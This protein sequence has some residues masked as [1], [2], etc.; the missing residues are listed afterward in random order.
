MVTNDEVVSRAGT[1]RPE[2][3]SFDGSAEQVAAAQALMRA[4]P[5]SC[6]RGEGN[7]LSPPTQCGDPLFRAGW[8]P[9][10]DYARAPPEAISAFNP[11]LGA[12]DNGGEDAC[13][14]PAAALAIH[15]ALLTLRRVSRARKVHMAYLIIRG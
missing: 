11:A 8:F 5:V 14:A 7:T 1:H 13:A 9:Q 4:C 12:P 15:L 6:C 10:V 2:G 3:A